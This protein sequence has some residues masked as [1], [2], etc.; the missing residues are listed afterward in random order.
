[1]QRRG[2]SEQ[3]VKGQS[4]N[5]PE[6]CNAPTAQVS[7]DHSQGQLERLARERDEALER[8]AATAEVLKVISRSTFDLK[9]VLETLVQSAGKLCQAENVQIF[10]RDGEFYQ[11][12]CGQWLFARVPAVCERAPDQAGARHAGGTNGVGCRPSSN[13]GSTC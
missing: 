12:R 13:T 4:A 7:T 9:A 1:M 2:G 11:L 10:L 5:R 8:E 6:A 3:P